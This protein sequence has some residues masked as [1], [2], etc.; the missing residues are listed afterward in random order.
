MTTGIWESDDVWDVRRA[1]TTAAGAHRDLAAYNEAGVLEAADVHVARRVCAVAGDTDP[2]S[3]LAVALAVRAVRHGSVCLSLDDVAELAPELPWPATEDWRTALSTSRVCA[4]GVLAVE[5]GLV[6]LDR[7]RAQEQQVAD[8]LVARVSRPAP[9]VDDRLLAAALDRLYP[10]DRY[11]E[12]RAA[13]A[14]AATRWTTVLTGGPGTGKTTTVA[15][16]LAVLTEQ[17]GPDARIAL[18]AP[19][20]K[21]AARLQEQVLAAGRD[22]PTTDAARLEGLRA[23]TIHRLLGFRRDNHTRFRHDRSHRL[24]HDL[25][26]VDETSM[27]SLTMMARLLEA[28]RPDARLVLVG[29]P[30]QLASVEAGAVL[31]DLVTGFRDTPDSPVVEL[32]T[33][34]RFG[35]TIGELAAALRVGDA[36]AAIAVLRAGHDAVGWVDSDDP[37]DAERAIRESA[38]PAARAVREDAVAGEAAAALQALDRHRLLTP[39]RDTVRWWN[40]RIEQWLREA[41]PEAADL[42]RDRMYA[43]RPLLVTRNDAGLGVH[44]GDTGVV[45]R[46]G[47]GRVRAVLAGASGP[48]ELAP[49]RLADVETMHAMTIHKSQGSQAHEVTVLLPD[50]DSRL[51]TRE[52]L[53]TAVTRAQGGVRLIGSEESLR[54]ALAR[55]A[56]RASGLQRRLA[57]S[58]DSAET[59]RTRR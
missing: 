37:A 15:R 46:G 47:G 11:A 23:T 3:A 35:A 43:G 29:D 6:Y 39:H 20:G 40:S 27:V 31:D 51:L 56:Q 48:I 22:L 25:V 9:A 57:G 50:A 13:C 54:A 52:L 49:G 24:P 12:Q 18:A 38:L 5:H 32:G 55:R 21:A 42:L 45:V 14:G 1:V 2:R 41:E 26:V 59:T 19:T 17:L 10:D 36:D 34:H 7:Y 44:N 8:D 28:V 53:Y 58:L 33:V 16:I 4:A 30:D